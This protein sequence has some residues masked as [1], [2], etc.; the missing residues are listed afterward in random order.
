[1]NFK[2]VGG[3]LNGKKAPVKI[4]ITKITTV[5]NKLKMNV[6]M[7]PQNTFIVKSISISM[8]NKE[9]ISLKETHQIAFENN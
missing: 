1:M 9:N 2:Y 6:H 3:I 8:L 4:Q 5:I 7:I